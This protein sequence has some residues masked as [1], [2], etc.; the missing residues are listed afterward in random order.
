MPENDL[1]GKPRRV[2]LLRFA[3]AILA[4]IVLLVMCEVLLRVFSVG[5]NPHFFVPVSGH[6]AMTGNEKFGQ[7]FF[8]VE[9]TQP[10]LRF[11]FPSHKAPGVCRIFVLGSSA[12]AGIPSVAYNFGR[13]LQVMLEESFPGQKFEVINTAM[14]AINSHVV[15]EIARECVRYEPDLFVVY[16]GNNEMVGPYGAGTIFRPLNNMPAIRAGIW[17]RT[18]RTGQLL[19]RLEDAISS[20]KQKFSRWQGMEMFMGQNVG[21]ADPKLQKVYA[22]FQENLRDICTIAGRSGAPVVLCT[23]PTNLRDCPPFSSLHATGLSGTALQTWEA[24]YKRGCAAQDARKWNEAIAAYQ[25]AFASD[26]SYAE[27]QYRLAQ[28]L[29]ETGQEEAA[30]MH[31]GLAR[32]FDALRF[33]ADA[34]INRIIRDTAGS[35]GAS[36]VDAEQGLA[37]PNL[38]PHGLPGD[39]LFYEHCHLTF[40]GNY[41]FAALVFRRAADLI[42]MSSPAAKPAVELP[43]LDICAER[44]AYTDWD[45]QQAAA[46]IASMMLR[47]PFTG[48]LGSEARSARQVA[49]LSAME[50]SLNVLRLAEDQRIYE[51]ALA[52]KPDDLVL[53]LN[54]VR[55]LNRRNNFEAAQ[56]HWHYLVDALPEDAELRY[57]YGT[58]LVRLSKLAESETQLR[59]AIRLKPSNFQAH[60]NLG[61]ALAGLGRT[62]EAI[63]E[64]HCALRYNPQYATAH[65]NLAKLLQS[66]GKREEAEQH[67]AE[68]KRI[69]NETRTR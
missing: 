35:A 11:S 55:L 2:W 23:V 36:L 30:K 48:Q 47:P 20:D 39:E 60:A 50:Q 16:M 69:Q 40:K 3:L 66:K 52:R 68:A 58:A 49:G 34:S 41:E 14:V 10:P 7:R 13:V 45:S 62:D 56:E 43:S 6:D 22:H 51:R 21:S 26:S 32:D 44:L 64:C 57:D 17:L 12:A 4:P 18:T 63:R 37:S 67:L 31:F 1:P 38:S 9:L 27:L 8:P 59:E 53:R 19:S 24:A 15:R 28:C 54:L 33:R 5:Y 25:E 42:Y 29:L 61:I 65:E 46:K